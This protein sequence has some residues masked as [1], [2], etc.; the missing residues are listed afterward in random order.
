MARRKMATHVRKAP[1]LEADRLGA[2]RAVPDGKQTPIE[3]KD[4]IETCFI[5]ALPYQGGRTVA[6]PIVPQSGLKYT[7]ISE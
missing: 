5:I 2:G 1:F 3:Q 6:L 4:V 7:I